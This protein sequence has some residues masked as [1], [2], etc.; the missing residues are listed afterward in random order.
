MPTTLGRNQRRAGLRHDA[1]AREHEAELRRAGSDADVHRQGHGD[2]D[3]DGRAVDGRDDRLFRFE[4]AQGDAAAAVAAVLQARVVPFRVVEGAGA[5][6][7]V[8]AGAERAPGAGDDDRAHV[9]VGV[10]LAEG[11]DQ[12]V[13]HQARERVQLVGPVQG[14]RG[15]TIGDVVADVLVGVHAGDSML[16]A[17]RLLQSGMAENDGP[18]ETTLFIQKMDGELLGWDQPAARLREALD[19][20]DLV[21]WAQPVVRLEPD[22]ESTGAPPGASSWR[23]CWCGCGRKDRACCRPAISCPPSSTT[24]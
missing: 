5:G 15:D 14:D 7:Q 17:V 21:L 12:L 20:D 3:A 6:G 1:A 11:R 23:R 16:A 13:A 8:G 22:A 4:D 18:G 24:G 2:A 19:G 9:V 10:G